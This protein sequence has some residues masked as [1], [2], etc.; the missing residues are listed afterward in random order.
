M[1]IRT[2][3]DANFLLQTDT[4]VELFRRHAER[5]PIA[6]YHTRL[7]ADLIAANEP[8]ANLTA[9]WIEPDAAKWRLMRA[10]GLTE[11]YITGNRPPYDKFERWAEIL[12]QAMRHPIYHQAHM[13]L[14]RVFGIQETLKPSNARD[15]YESCTAKL[16]TPEY[17]P[18]AILRR[19]RVETLATTD[20]PA[21]TLEGH[22]ALR[23]Q[24]TTA[25]DLRVLPT[26]APSAVLDL[27][28]AE[29]YNAYLDRLGAA[30]DVSIVGYGDLLDA[31]RRRHKAFGEAGCVATLHRL[32]AF[33]DA[34]GADDAEVADAALRKVREGGA[35]TDDECRSFRAMLLHDLAA[36]DAEE[37]RVQMFH[38]GALYDLNPRIGKKSG[39]DA[40]FDAPSDRPTAAQMAR[41]F[42]QLDAEGN[43][44]QTIV[45]CYSPS[46]SQA[47]AGVAACFADRGV[48]MHYAPAW[49]HIGRP[50]FMEAQLDVLSAEGLVAQSVGFASG[51]RTLLAPVRHEYFRR[52]VCDVFGREV[53]RGLLPAGDLSTIKRTIENL[54]STNARRLM[55]C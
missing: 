7:N 19:L 1:M 50:A 13:E 33:P 12:P 28:D 11:D 27:R 43:L 24:A 3:L 29:R 32:A 10:A 46:E 54:C 5:L 51:A 40:G 25:D 17:L 20:D 15:I 38:V 41:F 31:L 21:D 16:Q 30:A 53:E 34:P 55:D 37:G 45:S 52:V 2:F 48:R 9:L 47:V 8:I 35:P 49:W 14:N 39:P 22:L 36:M 44:A 23:E 26:W 4:A 18:Q 42:A 6:D